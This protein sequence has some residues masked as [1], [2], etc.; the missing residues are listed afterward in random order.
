[1]I[2]RCPRP[3]GAF[4]NGDCDRLANEQYVGALKYVKLFARLGIHRRPLC[5]RLIRQ[6]LGVQSE[7]RPTR[8]VAAPRPW[9]PTGRCGRVR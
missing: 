1:M 3:S 2:G 4:R 9:Y 5:Q 7:R 6:A 8:Q